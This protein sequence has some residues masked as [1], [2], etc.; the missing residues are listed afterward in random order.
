MGKTTIL[1]AWIA[2]G[3]LA[4]PAWSEKRLPPGN[5]KKLVESDCA[6]CHSLSRITSRGHTAKDWQ[7]IVYIMFNAGAPL[8]EDQ[9]SV[10]ATYLAKN[11]PALNEP[12]RKEVSDFL[13]ALDDHD[14]VHRVYAAMK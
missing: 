1:C 5:G 6:S 2:V 8:R 11:F 14:D 4:L 3:V 13:N 9:I 10:V 12:A 7:N